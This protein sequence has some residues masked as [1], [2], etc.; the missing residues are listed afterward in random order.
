MIALRV[1]II[2]ILVIGAVGFALSL[3]I[4]IGKAVREYRAYRD[5]LR[6][7]R[8]EPRLL[9]IVQRPA[10][11][12]GNGAA[13]FR[14]IL[15]HAAEGTERRVIEAILCDHAVRLEGIAR[16]RISQAFEELGFVSRYMRGLT[17]P[18]W[19]RRADS[20]E[21]LGVARAERATEAL[22]KAMSDDAEEV[23]LRAAKALGEIRGRAAVG[24]LLEAL[25]QPNRW[26]TLRVAE[27]LSRMGE[28]AA[29][30]IV[31]AYGALPKPARLACL[32]ILGKLRRLETIDFLR[33][34]L[35]NGDPDERARAAHALGMTAHP[36]PA[37]DLV[38]AIHD[39]EWPVRAMA[40][41]ALG[42][43]ALPDVVMALA[44]A[45]TDREWWVRSNAASALKQMGPR[46]EQALLSVLSISDG[47]A[48]D[49][50]VLMLEESGILMSYVEALES[51]RPGARE[52]AEDLLSRI[53][54]LGS[55]DY[56]Q[57]QARHHP[58]AGI[59]GAL[60]GILLGR[61]S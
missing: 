36:G 31:E 48:R 19:W 54:K 17:A 7:R 23:R 43:I 16:E 32:D 56:L 55:V 49:Q 10:T 44:S 25:A 58:S 57:D 52:E 3:G 46:G 59:R 18:T 9:A 6:R 51:R 30:G 26:S 45:L 37:D 1:L 53:A 5:R 42:R 38:A 22:V 8:I 12:N 27:I 41:K 50:A 47:F 24:P 29:D 28:E 2:S 4:L 61:P 20:A 60:E 15:G 21:K 34:V 14:D 40:A 35:K 39:P 13:P 33:D 11:A